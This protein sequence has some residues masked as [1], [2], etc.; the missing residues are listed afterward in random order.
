MPAY[1]FRRGFCTLVL[2]F[3]SVSTSEEFLCQNN[4]Q[5]W[6]KY[7]CNM[8]PLTFVAPYYCSYSNSLRECYTTPGVPVIVS[9]GSVP[10]IHGATLQIDASTGWRN[11]TA[12]RLAVFPSDPPV[13]DF[14]DTPINVTIPAN[15]QYQHFSSSMTT[16]LM[17]M[18]RALK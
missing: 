2:S 10:Q 1:E 6:A 18:S 4:K 12:S 13:P 8:L 17:R 7:K 14:S 5:L 15:I 3:F 11:I 9:M 16:T